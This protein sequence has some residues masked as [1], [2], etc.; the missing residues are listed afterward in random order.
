M[1]NEHSD[2]EISPE[3]A[4]YLQDLR[5]LPFDEFRRKHSIDAN[6]NATRA[7]SERRSEQSRGQRG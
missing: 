6:A 3:A 2:D 1:A 4:T 5:A 7:R